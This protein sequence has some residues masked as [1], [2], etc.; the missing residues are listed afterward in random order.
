M[1]AIFIQLEPVFLGNFCQGIHVAGASREMDG[2][3]G[4]GLGGDFLLYLGGIHIQ[5][6]G[7]DVDQYRC[8][9]GVENRIDRC[10]KRHRCRDDLIP[11][12][13]SSCKNCKMQ[14]RG[15]RIERHCVRNFFVGCQGFFK[16]LDLRSGTKPA[17]S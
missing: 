13:N 15:A 5:G 4:L 10:T 3:D 16:R 12:A 8:C 9:P 7:V 17:T 14:C 1:G 11:F 2:K 6:F